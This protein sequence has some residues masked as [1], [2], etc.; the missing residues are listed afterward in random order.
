MASSRQPRLLGVISFMQ[1]RCTS[2]KLVSSVRFQLANR[3]RS[4]SAS[5]D[6]AHC[7]AS[8][9]VGSVLTS[10]R[11]PRRRTRTCQLPP[12]LRKVAIV[13][14]SVGQTRDKS[15]NL[16]DTGKRTGQ[17]LPDSSDRR[18]FSH[19]KK[20]IKINC[21]RNSLTSPRVSPARARR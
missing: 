16:G 1:R 19:S 2:P 8:T 15:E 18:S 14:L 6:H 17:R 20:F 5:I 9:L 10:S 12:R 7:S 3:P 4:I 21:L 11:C 13:F